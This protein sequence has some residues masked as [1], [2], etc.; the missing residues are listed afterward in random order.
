MINMKNLRR[1]NIDFNLPYPEPETGEFVGPEPFLR[2]MCSSLLRALDGGELRFLLPKRDGRWQEGAGHLHLFQ[3]ELFFQLRGGC[4]FVMPR[5]KIE[6]VAGDALLVPAGMS[7]FEQCNN[8]GG[9]P[10]T[11]AVLSVSEQ[12]TLFHVAIA[13][14]RTPR[15]AGHDL[16]LADSDFY[17]S[18]LA[19]LSA[20]DDCHHEENT[21]IRRGLLRALLLKLRLD[22]ETGSGVT[23]VTGPVNPLSRRA[24]RLIDAGG[25]ANFSSVS[26]LAEKLGCSP[27]YLSAVFRRDCGI[28]LKRY[29]LELRLEEAR[30][31]LP[32]S[33]FNISEI[34]QRCGFHDASHLGRMFRRRFGRSPSE[35]R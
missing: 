23:E 25:G 14:G 3:A 1:K 7:H 5:Q 10:F 13:M 34:A 4:T 16:R 31:L 2:Q 27:N 8:H 30:K 26:Q 18:L 17:Q 33:D 9:H 6:L 21:A 35:L 15:V 28:G 11:N 32:D 29:M 19:A 22:L 24:K 20:C 12:M